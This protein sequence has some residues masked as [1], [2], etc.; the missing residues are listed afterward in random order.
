MS[1][2]NDREVF[3]KQDRSEWCETVTDEIYN[4]LDLRQD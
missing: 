4:E 1:K 3:E 2:I